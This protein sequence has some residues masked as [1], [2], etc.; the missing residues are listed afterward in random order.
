[1]RCTGKREWK[2][3]LAFVL[4]VLIAG[5]MPSIGVP[6][7]MAATDEYPNQ[8]TVTVFDKSNQPIT[9]A[10]VRVQENQNNV[11]ITKSTDAN[12]VVALSE[13]NVLSSFPSK[14]NLLIS[15][16]GYDTIFS[17]DY[18]LR[19]NENIIVYLEASPKVTV[20]AS[21]SSGN[22]TIELN[23]TEQSSV[24][25]VKD[26]KVP[27]K[28][29]PESGSYIKTISIN[30][31]K[32][33]NSAIP[34]KGQPYE[35][36]V[37]AASDILIQVEI[38]KQYTVSVTKNDGG[39]ILV[40]GGSDASVSVDD[41]TGI[42]VQVEAEE[43]YRIA[44]LSIDGTSYANAAGKERF[45]VSNFTVTKDISIEVTF[46]QVYTITVTSTGNGFVNTNPA[47]EGGVVTVDTGTDVTITATPDTNH[48]V[49]DVTINGV[50]D[51]TVTGSNNEDYTKTLR[52]DKDYTVAITF[53]P[54][55]YNIRINN[56]SN[57]TI[58]PEYSSMQHGA[59][60]RVYL[61]PDAGFTVDTVLVNNSSVTNITRDASG[62]YF[63][64]N[65][66]VTDQNV[67]VT[68]KRSASGSASDVTVKSDAALRKNATDTLFVIK[69]GDA[70]VF[71]T[72]KNGLRIYDEQDELVGGDESTQAVPVSESRVVKRVQLYYQAADEL[73]ADWHDVEMG[74]IQV[75]ADK[76]R[77]ISILTP[78]IAANTNGYYNSDITFSAS[79]VDNGEYSGIAKIEYW[80]ACDSADTAHDVLYEYQNGEIINTYSNANAIVVDA[81]KYNSQDVKVTWKV[82][83]RAGN[84][85][86]VEKIL[87]INSTAP[88]LALDI[89]GTQNA[90]ALDGYYNGERTLTITI[91]DREDTFDAA[92]VAVG[93]VMKANDNQVSVQASDI[94]WVHNGSSHIGTYRF[95]DDAEYEWSISYTN[96][97]G[98]SNEGVSAPIDKN[99][100]HF[101]IDNA[102]PYN[103]KVSY[104]PVVFDTILEN[105]TFGFYKAP[106]RVTIEAADDTAGVE[107]FV[108][109]Y[110]N[111]SGVGSA[112]AGQSDIVVRSSEI[113]REGKKASASFKIPAQ[114]RGNVTFQAMDRA[115]NLAGLSDNKV[116]VVDD[117][118]PEIS[119]TYD[120]NHVM[121][122]ECFSADRIAT[123]RVVER[124]FKASDVVAT[125]KVNNEI[126]D[127]YTSYLQDESNWV[128]DGDIHTATIAFTEEGC[129]SFA[130]QCTDRSGNTNA[131]V[132]FGTS[133]A[134]TEF[135]LD[136]S[137][138]TDLTIKINGASVLGTNSIVYDTF[139]SN[140]VSVK[141][142]ANCGVSGIQSL[143]YQKVATASAY[144]PNGT[145]TA[146]D[147]SRGIVVSPSEKFI[148]YFR[149]EDRAGNVSIVNSTGIVVDN[150]KP[151]GE[152][153]APEIDILP[154]A[155]NANEVYRGNV[156]VSLKVIDPKYTGSTTN[157]EG[158]YS[159]LN[160]I[161]YRIYASDIDTIAEGTLFDRTNM[162]AGAEF[163]GDNLVNAWSGRITVDAAQFNSNYVVVEVTATDNAG[164]VRSSSTA[165]GA[166][167]IDTTAPKIKVSY[168]NNSAEQ[169]TFFNQARVATI[170]V[171]E[172]NFNANDVKLALTNTDGVIPSLSAWNMTAGT[173]NGDNI[174]WSANLV[175][176]QD[177]DYEFNISYTDLAGNACAEVE[178]GDSVAPTKFTIDQTIPDIVVS[179]D[180]NEAFNGNY[181]N[182][183][184][185]A[186]IVITEHNLDPNGADKDRIVVTMSA[187]DDGTAVTVPAISRWTTNGDRHTAT[188]SYA[189]DALYTFDIAVKDKAGNASAEFTPQSFYV[190]RTAPSI[191]ISGVA[192]YS[193]NNGDVIP[194]ITYSDTNF[195]P[196]QVTVTLSGANRKSVEPD[197]TYENIY[198]GQTFTFHNFAKEKMIDDIYTLTVTLNDKAGNTSTES[199]VFS[200]NRFGSTYALSESTE[201]MNGAYVQSPTDVVIREINT[202]K[203]SNIKITLFKN[204]ETITLKNGV[205]YVIE[206]EGGDG[207]WYQ[208]TYTIFAQNFADDGVYRVTVHSEDAAGNLAENTLDTKDTEVTFGVDKTKPNIIV[209]NLESKTTYAVEKL[210]VLISASDNLLLGSVSVYLD[211]T[212]KPYKTWTAEEITE[213]VAAG[214]AFSFDIPGDSTSAHDVKIVCADA[215]GNETV[216]E[217]N[218][219]YVTTN[220][221]VRFYTNK[222]LLFGSVAGV[223]VVAGLIVFLSKRSFFGMLFIKK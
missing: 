180:N 132:D 164:N 84:E 110:A 19:P 119:V 223:S 134:P 56:T 130:I 186:T 152:T 81:S 120:N 29:V 30:G 44:A 116:I 27:V 182:D 204:N 65:N 128:H 89:A 102:A 25:V 183:I 161:T 28:I 118:A 217:I 198:H 61:T 210:T 106:V 85:E 62:V 208:Y 1:M 191:Q 16:D 6:Q 147:S 99:I 94:Q 63:T 162:V 77:T 112:N 203:L 124:Y 139:Y 64:I 98:K 193:A 41:G 172:R 184:R 179:Y 57:G 83:D 69:D 194:V 105:I 141:L 218:D 87:N 24:T 21:V 93:I 52:A 158:Y 49:T 33:D 136:K 47:G 171:T 86:S 8:V 135:I 212:G 167:K 13:L 175:Y 4:S 163:D 104:A 123:I 91:V 3:V 174:Q 177:G 201:K 48:R 138:P 222:P 202:D 114:F 73:Y 214:G 11:D 34:A 166:I 197:G 38:V 219:F 144:H 100:Y 196:K 109:S 156:D 215:A 117:I 92:A 60:A 37:T 159:G 169:G 176:D 14:I 121:N 50:K 70:I 10:S 126:V 9:G 165:P 168:S 154:S 129:Y 209:T 101:T 53:A 137:A 72:D 17:P 108:Y 79:V 71:S 36:T 200:V 51:N 42:N 35:S 46:V 68:F 78:T 80:I 39:S 111:Q 74:Q 88:T 199:I 170:V 127:S 190:D 103:L 157:A 149:A 95:T 40:N 140:E 90:N 181:Y 220:L 125:V 207:Q 145:W 82:T 43:N 189:A 67:Q 122:G 5:S 150:Q 221:F 55:I 75:V 185:N 18:E 59:N 143:Q 155:S 216:E 178:Y 131:V 113:V 160:R 148:I 188:I 26:T 31:V 211:D 192:N 15:K 97:A 58:R 195:D 32:V 45:S 23:N 133:A 2:R 20:S 54:N 66:I 142:A 107:Q 205:D 22:A 96:K 153:R 187:L 213:I 206:L 173:G 76:E 146:Y 151:T 7:V 12:G 115:G